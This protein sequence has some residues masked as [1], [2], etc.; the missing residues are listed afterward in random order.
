MQLHLGVP[1]PN[2]ISS[3]SHFKEL[4]RVS[5]CMYEFSLLIG[6]NWYPGPQHVLCTTVFSVYQSWRDGETPF[7]KQTQ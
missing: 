7:T 4:D 5:S 2:F 3:F 6:Y 1:V